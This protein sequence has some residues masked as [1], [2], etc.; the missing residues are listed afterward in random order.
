VKLPAC[1]FPTVTSGSP[2]IVVTSLALLFVVLL[3]PPPL[4]VAVF[5]TLAGAVLA[6]FTVNVIAG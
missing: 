5:V 1:V 4:T 3:S 6:T 2:L